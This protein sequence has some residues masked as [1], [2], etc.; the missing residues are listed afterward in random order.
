MTSVHQPCRLP[1]VAFL[2]RA[3]P[4]ADV[5][6]LRTAAD[7][8]GSPP[9]SKRFLRH[10]D[11]QSVVA[12]R[13]V[14]QAVAA[15]SETDISHDG[16]IAAPCQA[17]RIASS[18]TLSKY[19]TGGGVT[20]STRI[21]PQ[22]SLHAVAA[23]VSVGLGMHGP[24]LGVGGGP[25]AVVEGLLTAAALADTPGVTGW[26]LIASQLHAEPHLDAAGQPDESR[27]TVVEA[28]A[29]RIAAANTAAAVSPRWW[30]SL[31]ERHSNPRHSPPSQ[32]A[33]L[34]AWLESQLIAA[35]A[36]EAA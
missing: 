8:A 6:P 34:A 25:E 12:V 10:A 15:G 9:L 14:Q 4:L 36:K 22:A 29:M 30:F 16:V 7:P 18:Q 3:V 23:V 19:A 17:G 24:S 1:V 21:V 2:S 27:H 28:V 32:P 13:A 35:A 5:E 11:E 31:D 20:V 33:S 26:W